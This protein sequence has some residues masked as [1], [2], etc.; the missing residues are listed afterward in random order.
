VVEQVLDRLDAAIVEAGC[1]A[2]ADALDVADRR[3]EREGLVRGHGL[4]ASRGYA[5][6]LGGGRMK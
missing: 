5:C 4:D 6:L 1:D 3:V 2:L